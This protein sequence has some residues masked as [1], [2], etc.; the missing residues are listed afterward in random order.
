MAGKQWDCFLGGSTFHV[1]IDHHSLIWLNKLE[2]PSRRQS[3]WVYMPQGH[4]FALLDI[5]GETNPADA[6]TR[7]PYQHDGI[8]INDQPTKEPIVVL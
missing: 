6:F 5:K 4:A 8:G 1:L 7:V 2:D 3:R